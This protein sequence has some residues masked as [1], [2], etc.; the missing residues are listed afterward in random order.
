MKKAFVLILSVLLILALT[1]CVKK[2]GDAAGDPTGEAA[3]VTVNQTKPVASQTPVPAQTANAADA[4]SFKAADSKPVETI[5]NQAEYLLYQNIFF[6]DMAGDYTS[7]PVTK[8]GIF[9][10]IEDYFNNVTRYYVWGYMDKTK[11]CDWQWEL[12]VP[13][14]Q[15]AELP[16]PGSVITVSGTFVGD[17]NALDKYWITEPVIEVKKAYENDFDGMDLRTLDS[18]L[19][20]VQMINCQQF[21]DKVAGKQVAVYGRVLN[22]TAIQHPYYDGSWT[23]DVDAGDLPGI[24]T[25]VEIVGTFKDGILT[26]TVALTNRF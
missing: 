2:T 8:E 5:I 17:E 12:K 11:C 1:A 6:N 24:G 20:R 4:A 9:A 15:V 13:A 18:T 10:K 16:A 26:G 23:Q 14:E 7:K 3:S 25:M 19:E 22:I 21:P